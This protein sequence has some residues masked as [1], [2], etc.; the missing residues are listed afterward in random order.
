AHGGDGVGGVGLPVGQIAP[1]RNLE[2]AQHRVVQVAAAHH[3]EGHGVLGDRRAVPQR[4]RLAA[5]VDQVGVHIL[6]A[7]GGTH[8]QDAVFA[9]Q[10]DVPVGRQVVAHQGRHADAQIDDGAV[11]DVAGQ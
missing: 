4:D 2:G 11:G 9:V 5:G 6:A 3:G 10:Q 8:A 1:L 7:G